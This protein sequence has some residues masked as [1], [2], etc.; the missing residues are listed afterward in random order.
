VLSYRAFRGRRKAPVEALEPPSHC[1]Q[2]I[3]PWMIR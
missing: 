1:T 3:L 2:T